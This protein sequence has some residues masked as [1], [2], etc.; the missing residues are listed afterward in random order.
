[1]TGGGDATEFTTAPGSAA[2]Q[3]SE[4]H[5]QLHGINQ[6]PELTVAVLETSRTDAVANVDVQSVT[7]SQVPSSL[8]SGGV[9]PCAGCNSCACSVLTKVQTMEDIVKRFGS[10]ENI[11][12]KL[13]EQSLSAKKDLEKLKEQSVSD[14]KDWEKQVKEI[15]TKSKKLENINQTLAKKHDDLVK[16]LKSQTKSN[17]PAASGRGGQKRSRNPLSGSRSGSESADDKHTDDDEDLVEKPASKRKKED[18]DVL[19][20]L[21]VAKEL[22]R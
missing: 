11:V 19:D 6:D 2:T 7:G 9:A 8:T 3:E 17:K 13:K 16:R 14:K 10:M 15:Q 20:D 4:E 12:Q 18:H 5:D 22:W 1:M 21:V